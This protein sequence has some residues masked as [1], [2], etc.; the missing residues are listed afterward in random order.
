[1]KEIT[2]VGGGLAGLSLGLGLRKRGVPVHLLEGGRYP[3]HKV[4]GEFICGVDDE[5]LAELGVLDAMEGALEHRSMRW[6]MGE[7]RVLEREMPLAARGISRYV[8]DQRLAQH[9][10][11]LGGRLESGVRARDLAQRDGLVWASGKAKTKGKEWIGLKSHYHMDDV[12]GLEMHVGS[13]GYVGLCPVDQ[14]TV[15]VCAL[16]RVQSG[17]KGEDILL[18][19]LEANGLSSLADRL[20]AAKETQGAFVATAGF[21]LG[22]QEQKPGVH[23]GD[24]INLI[25]PFTGNGMSMALESSYLLLPLLQRYAEGALAWAEVELEYRARAEE[26]FSKRMTLATRLHPLLF[27]RFTRQMMAQLLRYRILPI[28]SLFTHLRQP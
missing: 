19:Y 27:K 10:E 11:Q 28:D 20:K 6:W 14:S 23:V 25:P 17:L 21:S 18:K 12:D 16:F 13:A 8:L 9:F 22:K 1:M 5:V 3:Q 15:N 7:S 2:I 26:Y 24:A 4:C